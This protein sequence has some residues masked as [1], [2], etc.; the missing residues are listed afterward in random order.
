MLFNASRFHSRVDAEGNILPMSE[1]D[2]SKWDQDLILKG[3]SYIG[4][5]PLPRKISAYHILAAI[6]AHHCVSP[7]YASTDW[8]GILLLYDSLVEIDPSPVVRL[9]RTVALA[10]VKGPQAALDELEKIR[11]YDAL[12]SY[13]L[14]HATEG[15]FYM[16]MHCFEAAARC[17]QAAIDLAPLK[18][19]KQLLEKKLEACR[20]QSV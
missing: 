18:T 14:F 15:A 12:Q 16:E 17:L 13:Y 6:S 5:G 4:R 2:R 10:R 3:F 8:A 9:N 19:E 11:Q 7:D 1:Q 20:S